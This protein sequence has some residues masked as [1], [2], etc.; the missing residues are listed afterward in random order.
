VPADSETAGAVT[1]KGN[2]RERI[3]NTAETFTEIRILSWISL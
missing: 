1:V 2:G 3:W